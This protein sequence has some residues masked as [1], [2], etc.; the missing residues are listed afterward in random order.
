MESTQIRDLS[1][2]L[3]PYVENIIHGPLTP[4]SYTSVGHKLKRLFTYQTSTSSPTS[5]NPRDDHTRPSPP[6]MNGKPHLH[7]P[8]AAPKSA[9]SISIKPIPKRSSKL[10]IEACPKDLGDAYPPPTPQ[11]ISSKT[12]PLPP[13]PPQSPIPRPQRRCFQDPKPLSTIPPPSNSNPIALT[14][15]PSSLRTNRNK[16]LENARSYY[17]R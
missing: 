8:K 11:D 4:S 16:A 14:R 6:V 1:T 10:L 13:P 3:S 7:A 5:P 12:L 15:P 2:T 9:S 17:F